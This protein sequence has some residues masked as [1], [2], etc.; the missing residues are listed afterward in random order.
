MWSCGGG[1]SSEG[2][3]SASSEFE[4]AKSE[5]ASDITRV[6]KDLPPPSEVPFLLMATGSDFNPE[7]VNS[8]DNSENYTTSVTKSALNLQK[9]ISLCFY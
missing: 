3:S 7:L 8:L 4:A 1:G 9:K 2:T 5:I 6:I